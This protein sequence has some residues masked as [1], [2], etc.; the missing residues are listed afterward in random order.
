MSNNLHYHRHTA[1]SSNNNSR[2]RKRKKKGVAGIL[3]GIS[4]FITSLRSS[5]DFTNVEEEEGY[6]IPGDI[7]L[8]PYDEIM[9]RNYLVDF[10]GRCS[11]NNHSDD[12]NIDVHSS[13][14]NTILKRYDEISTLIQTTTDDTN[15]HKDI[16]WNH[17]IQLFTL[18]QFINDDARGYIAFN[19]TLSKSNGK[20]QVSSIQ[21]RLEESR[22]NGNGMVVKQSD[23]DNDTLDMMEDGD[24]SLLHYASL[25]VIP[26]E[27]SARDKAREMLHKRLEEGMPSL[28]TTTSRQSKSSLLL[29]ISDD[30]LQKMEIGIQE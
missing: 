11:S 9:I 21:E 19:T 2:I 22:L 10:G 24:D 15:L 30:Q 28:A 5:N 17:I 18:C 26:N 20:D 14:E 6:N 25:L 13:N 8:E 12:E 4:N 23:N 16:L 1:R 7:V 29:E 27:V 3:L